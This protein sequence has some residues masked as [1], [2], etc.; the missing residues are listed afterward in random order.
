MAIEDLADYIDEFAEIIKEFGQEPVYY[1]HAG[2][3][4]IHLRPILDLKKSK[5]VE[6]FYQIS[7]A[8]AKLVKKYR[9]SLSGEHGD[10]RVRAA[11]IPLMVGQENY[12]LFKRVKAAWD[13]KGIFNPGKIVDA[14]HEYVFAL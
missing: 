3:G 2:A 14:P 11:F 5:D 9:G 10:G 1:A 4:E 6:E 12:D 7:E 13:P 8:S